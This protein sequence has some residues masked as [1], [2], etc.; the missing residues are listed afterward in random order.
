MSDLWASLCIRL[1]LLRAWNNAASSIA[2]VWFLNKEVK[3]KKLSPSIICYSNNF[4]YCQCFL[5]IVAGIILKIIFNNFKKSHAT[6]WVLFYFTVIIDKNIFG[7]PLLLILQRTGQPM[8]QSI[9]AAIHYLQT[10]SLDSTGLFRKSGVKSR[11]QKLKSLNESNPENMTYE[12]QQAYDVA[13]MI[14][15]YFRELPEALLTNKLSETF[16]SIFQCK[17][18]FFLYPFSADVVCTIFNIIFPFKNNH[19][20]I[21]QH[22]NKQQYFY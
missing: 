21:Y 22:T 7:V 4:N 20:T 12:G 9:Q 11:I 1:S 5:V 8:P 6:K 18:V 19:L 3:I 2:D 14:K 15:Q 17:F 10:T 16:I 13:D